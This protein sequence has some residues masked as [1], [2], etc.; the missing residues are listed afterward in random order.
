M[1]PL[2][3]SL[4]L[5]SL[6]IVHCAAQNPSPST[7][8]KPVII[9]Q[10]PPSRTHST[11]FQNTAIT[12]S[13]QTS[14]SDSSNHSL[15]FASSNETRWTV[16]ESDLTEKVF[17]APVADSED[18][19]SPGS[20]GPDSSDVSASRVGPLV[21]AYYSDWL[22]Q[23][24]PPEEINYPLYDLIDFAFAL[25]TASFELE[26]DDNDSCPELLKKLVHYAHAH[27]TKVKLSI[28]GWTGSRYFSSAVENVNNRQHFTDNIWAFYKESELDGIDIDWEYPGTKANDGNQV[29]PVDSANFLAFLRL[30]RRA[31]PHGAILTAAAT[32]LP[33]AGPDGRPM[34]DV[35]SFARVLDWVLIMNYDTWGVSSPPG[36]NAPLFDACGNSTQPQS[37]AVAAYDAWTK[38]GFPASQLVLG[39][40]TYGYV[41]SSDA[42]QFRTREELD[43]DPSVASRVVKLKSDDDG[44]EGTVSVRR[45]VEQGALVQD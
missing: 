41:M 35:S 23:R 22:A 27:G 43:Q 36:P 3:S 21:M 39:L 12:N 14:S 24:L 5:A 44:Q 10:D 29:S 32:A 2:S 13:N 40:P 4:Y 17:I 26:W 9:A 33:F 19:D 34:G 30:L 20:D 31:L 18:P 42:Q 7:S 28:G 38:A 6:A 1:H 11:P 15:S 37:S 16:F 8:L 45:M 25:P